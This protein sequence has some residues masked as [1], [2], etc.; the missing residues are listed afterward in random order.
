MKDKEKSSS[1]QFII[2][3]LSLL[4]VMTQSQTAF[5]SLPP[6]YSAIIEYTITNK[7][8]TGSLFEIYDPENNR[9]FFSSLSEG[10]V[11][12]SY[13]FTNL[14]GGSEF[15][16]VDYVNCSVSVY[17]R[18][19]TFQTTTQWF[20][21]EVH[22]TVTI[23]VGEDTVRGIP[24][25]V[26][27]N[28]DATKYFYF[29]K[30]YWTLQNTGYYRTPVRI[31][32]EGTNSQNETYHHNYEYYSFEVGPFPD[33]YFELPSDLRCGSLSNPTLPTLPQTFKATIE[34][35]D[36]VS[37]TTSSIQEFVDPE[38]GLMYAK[39]MRGDDIYRLVYN[40]QD[41]TLT[42][43]TNDECVISSSDASFANQSVS[44]YFRFG[45][46]YDVFYEGTTFV[47]GIP[48]ERW[49]SE[50]KDESAYGYL[51]YTVENHFSLAG[52]FLLG[53][54]FPEERIPLKTIIKGVFTPNGSDPI[55]IHNVYD[56]IGFHH[57]EEQDYQLF[58]RDVIS[59]FFDCKSEMS[60]D[61]PSL[62]NKFRVGIEFS[63]ETS[64]NDFVLWVDREEKK[65][66]AAR[67][68]PND[69]FVINY[70]DRDSKTL[71]V[72]VRNDSSP[73][74]T[75]SEISEESMISETDTDN[76]WGSIYL[77]HDFTGFEYY[78]TNLIR[79]IRCDKWISSGTYSQGNDYMDYHEHIYF[80]VSEWDFDLE[81][82]GTNF[83][84]R[85]SIEGTF[86]N[87]NI[88]RSF[89]FD[90][91][92]YGF[93]SGDDAFPSEFES[94]SADFHCASRN[95]KEIPSIPSQFSTTIEM[96]H[97]DDKATHYYNIWWD[98]ISGDYRVDYF[99]HNTKHHNI[100]HMYEEIQYLYEEN[101]QCEHYDLNQNVV[102]YGSPITLPDI[103]TMSTAGYTY[104]GQ[105]EKRGINC[106]VWYTTHAHTENEEVGEYN[107][108]WFFLA[109][110]T[111]QNYLVRIEVTGVITFNNGTVSAI[112]DEYDF[113]N[114]IIGSPISDV[115]DIPTEWGCQ[116]TGSASLPD[117]SL[118]MYLFITV[119]N[120]FDI[121]DVL[122]TVVEYSG[123][124][125]NMENDKLDILGVW[126]NNSSAFTFLFLLSDNQSTVLLQAFFESSARMEEAKSA[127][128]SI[129]V[130]PGV[131][132]FTWSPSALCPESCGEGFCHFGTCICY[133]DYVGETCDRRG[134]VIGVI[135]D[136][137]P[138]EFIFRFFQFLY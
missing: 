8:Y 119:N 104:I 3:C 56:I 80:P 94:P 113:T 69:N 105:I 89:S 36:L 114:F 27:S 18:E 11:K 135:T 91:D 86:K 87:G 112:E 79:G 109:D 42:N 131:V 61:V 50:L 138:E 66:T 47:R 37:N 19:T 51:D 122:V 98:S 39:I 72:V 133:G 116:R 100:I 40:S 9:I 34:A 5:P 82:D 65:A 136:R 67:F 53:D 96:N 125:T 13:I 10:V 24:C 81:N 84:L 99:D 85:V 6:S 124:R 64:H 62:P 127:L 22:N 1:I 132:E 35:T 4:V 70:W 123:I 23:Y 121:D 45:S 43:I 46:E 26:W 41:N 57:M 30:P 118:S 58:E 71:S 75:V 59:N 49:I 60:K 90:Y 68:L 2:L 92:Y 93:T 20:Q 52:W 14:N 16:V 48:A 129:S 111:L 88:S 28:E 107:I 108:Y 78:G 83:P 38:Q 101:G 44:Q 63:S 115:F 110:E 97:I 137:P 117:A 73:T 7:G 32:V 74:C 130:L 25:D 76:P 106:D 15:T 17:N 103:F 120:P 12:D 31:T 54:A 55:P 134:G 29:A 21:Q 126:D 33:S 128:E 102:D 95:Q 77:L